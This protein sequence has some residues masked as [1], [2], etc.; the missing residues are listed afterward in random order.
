MSFVVKITNRTLQINHFQIRVLFQCI[1]VLGSH[2]SSGGETAA[3]AAELLA[4]LGGIDMESLLQAHDQAAA[5]LDPACFSRG[6]RQVPNLLR[7]HKSLEKYAVHL[8]LLE[9][10]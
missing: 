6:R 5:L 2:T 3:L 7:K 1:D 9:M 10:Y 4:V 8:H